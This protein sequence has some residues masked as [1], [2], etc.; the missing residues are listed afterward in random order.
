MWIA[1]R[2]EDSVHVIYDL[3][4]RAADIGGALLDWKAKGSTLEYLGTEDIDGTDAHKLRVTFKNGDSQAFLQANR[5]Q[6]GQ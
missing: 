1:A 2:R 3:F 6:G 5:Q 4:R